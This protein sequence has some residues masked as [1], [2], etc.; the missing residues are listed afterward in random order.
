VGKRVSQSVGKSVSDDIPPLSD[1]GMWSRRTGLERGVIGAVGLIGCPG[2]D[3]AGG[4]LRDQGVLVQ[5]AKRRRISLTVNG[6]RL[7]EVLPDEQRGYDSWR[8]NETALA[9]VLV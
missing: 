5:P 6:I 3:V 9:G 2:S 1:G 8:V 7:L 4:Y